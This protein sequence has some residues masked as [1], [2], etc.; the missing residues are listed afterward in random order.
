MKAFLKIVRAFTLLG[1]MWTLSPWSAR[2]AVSQPI[3]NRSA[4]TTDFT[5]IA[6]KPQTL[7]TILVSAADRTVTTGAVSADKKTIVFRQ[8]VVKLVVH[9]GP[10]RDM[11][12]YRVNGLRNPTIVVPR[13]AKLTVLFINNDGDMFHNIRFGPWTARFPTD[14]DT[15]NKQSVGVAPLPHIAGTTLHGAELVIRA[16]AKVGKYTY[17]CTVRGHAPG[18]MWGTIQTK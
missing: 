5:V 7:S 9:T 18:G 16:P 11:L 1:I 13:G 17:F 8:K 3:T 4:P 15:L 10:Y 6:I 14:M 12:S 2:A